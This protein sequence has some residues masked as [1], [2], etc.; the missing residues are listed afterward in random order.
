MPRHLAQSVARTLATAYI[1]KRRSPKH[2][3]CWV[4]RSSIE[5][6]DGR[7]EGVCQPQRIK[8]FGDHRCAIDTLALVWQ[9][10]ATRRCENDARTNARASF[11]Q[12]SHQT[13]IFKAIGG[14]CRG[15]GHGLGLRRAKR[16]EYNALSAFT[17]KCMSWLAFGDHVATPRA[18]CC[19]N[20]SHSIHVEAQVLKALY[21]LGLA[22][23]DRGLGWSC[24][25][26]MPTTTDKTVWRLLLRNRHPRVGLAKN[27]DAAMRE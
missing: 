17:S 21:V 19:Q 23:I 1:A 8:R 12:S 11:F 7:V 24:R 27:C 6:W 26:C 2:C 13:V 3:M 14:T 4:W 20:V 10:I 18:E 22:L 16:Y 15:R 5:A 9:R 25:R